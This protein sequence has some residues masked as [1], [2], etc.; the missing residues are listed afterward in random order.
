MLQVPTLAA[1]HAAGE[2]PEVVFWVGCAGSFD[3]RA[4]R[5]TK[6][7]IKILHHSLILFVFFIYLVWYVTYCPTCC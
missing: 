6:A 1:M 3:E 7:Y 5:I 2:S 4:K